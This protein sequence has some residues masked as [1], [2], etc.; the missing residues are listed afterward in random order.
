MDRP[1]DA[2]DAGAANLAFARSLVHEL[3]ACG[4][5]TAVVCP[6]SRSAPLALAVA[7]EPG[8]AHSVHIDERNAAFHA[9]GSAKAT[10]QPV[11][12]VCTSGTAGANFLPAVAEACQ[13]RVPLI[14]L[15]ADRPPE[16]RAWGA[17]QTMEQ[18]TLFAG[19]TRWSEESP[20]PSEDG[21]GES[22]AR[23]LA[24]R[25]VSEAMGPSPGPVHLNLP[26]REPLL[27][28]KI[29]L[30]PRAPRAPA[31]A[32]A[33]RTTPALEQVA[34]LAK[35]LQEV[36]RGVL[37]FG[38]ES[39]DAAPA[40]EVRALADRL[41]WPVLAD[42]ASGLRAGLALEDSLVCA[43]DLLLRSADAAAA[44]A[45]E[46]IVRFGGLPTSKA[47]SLWMACHPAAEVWL[48]DPVSAFRDPQHRASR[49]VRASAGAFCAAI[50]T[51]T[52][53]PSRGALAWRARWRAADR[54]ARAALEEAM[55]VE[56]RFS[57]PQLASSL[58][59]LLP[60][61]ATLYAANSMAIRELDAFAGPRRSRLQVLANRGVNGID[62]QVSAAL[63]AA[64]ALGVPTVLWCG[65][66]AL[67]H[68]VSGLLAGRLHGADLTIVVSNDD[69]GGIFEYLPVAGI[70]P[71]AVFEEMFAV[72]HGL[73][74]GE[75]ATGLGWESSRVESA[76]S[77]E[78]ALSRA[79]VGGRHV[80]EV[81]V[82]RAANTAFHGRV[83]EAVRVAL[84]QEPR[85]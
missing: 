75:L 52:A 71:R 51:S 2:R 83:F 20:C 58:W 53:G 3:H 15:T 10:G 77:F 85:A 46:L 70:V 38:P 27:P 17:A 25:A 45:P 9:L 68:D 16:L 34:S 69:G 8:L 62:G 11:A 18:R 64:A 54:Q 49:S 48:V 19:F 28:A 39:G 13:A 76:A 67:L 26:F 80:I 4:V 42:P 79:L 65:D 29:D 41:G 24:R 14:V 35:Q 73:D 78:V 55:S 40:D 59:R 84:R 47:V 57:T 74:L 81:P 30:E 60:E 33:V 21:P 12:L 32:L 44:L 6:G 36:E 5:A 22:Y 61:A 23:A 82:D 50:A 37:V 72:P 43:A 1:N 56:S 63:G 7:A 31:R 66:L